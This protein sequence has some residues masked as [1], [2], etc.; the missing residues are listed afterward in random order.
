[1]SR[2]NHGSTFPLQFSQPIILV[3]GTGNPRALAASVNPPSCFGQESAVKA[4]N[5]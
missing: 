4:F 5:L 3:R 2:Q 1:M